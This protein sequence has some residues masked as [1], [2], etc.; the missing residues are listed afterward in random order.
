MLIGESGQYVCRVGVKTG[1]SNGADPAPS[2]RFAPFLAESLGAP[3]G[4][5]H[6]LE[7][8]D[9]NGSP[10]TLRNRCPKTSLASWGLTPGRADRECIGGEISVRH[11]Y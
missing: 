10:W 4:G 5:C 11:R 3:L 7:E 8:V 1:R 6:K 9:R 2:L